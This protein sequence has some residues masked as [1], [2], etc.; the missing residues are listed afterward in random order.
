MLPRAPE[1]F[2]QP[3]IY[4]LYA[5]PFQLTEVVFHWMEAVFAPYQ[6]YRLLDCFPTDAL[7]ALKLHPL[8][9]GGNIAVQNGAHVFNV[10]YPAACDRAHH[11][12]LPHHLVKGD[13]TL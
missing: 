6:L 3:F 1:V 8:L 12:E 10:L 7:D 5:I 13:N 2:G 4:T 9:D 11:N